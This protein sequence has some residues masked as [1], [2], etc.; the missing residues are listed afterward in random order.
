MTTLSEIELA[1]KAFAAA[2]DELTTTVNDLNASMDELRRLTLPTIKRKL[3]KAAER[4]AALHALVE[5]AAELFV[6]PRT[7]IFHGVKLG[8]EKGKGSVS[9]DDAEQVV[10]LIRKHLPDQFDALVKT[11]EKP[12]KAA[13]GALSV[14]EAKRIGCTVT[15][16]GDQVVI[17]PVDSEVDKM[18]DALLKN[19]VDAEQAE[20]VA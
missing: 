17:R 11:E 6:K 8:F 2:R 16:A 7:V 12:R 19:A 9:F 18:V 5:G 3:A 13:I 15:D 14:A 1:A 20:A 4:Q 10:K